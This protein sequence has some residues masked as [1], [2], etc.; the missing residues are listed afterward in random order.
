MKSINPQSIREILLE[1]ALAVVEEQW[2]MD[3]PDYR[4]ND[5]LRQAEQVRLE[6]GYPALEDFL[7]DLGARR[8]TARLSEQLLEAL[9]VGESYFFRQREQLE[10]VAGRLLPVMLMTSE[11]PV[12]MWSAGCSRGEEPFSLAIL[13]NY[14]G[15]GPESLQIL[16]TDLSESS[17]CRAREGRFRSFSMRG[18][19]PE[20][21]GMHF[22]QEGDEYE[23]H[24][25]IRA[26][27]RFARHNLADEVNPFGHHP[28][29]V[30]VCRNVLIYMSRERVEKVLRFLISCLAPGGYLVLGSSE[31]ILGMGL[32]IESLPLD[33]HGLYRR[34][35]ASPSPPPPRRPRPP[36]P[37]PPAAT[38]SETVMPPSPAPAP[39]PPT[40][41]AAGPDNA[42]VLQ[43]TLNHA[44]RLFESG[45][46]REAMEL[47]G[48]YAGTF[49]ADLAAAGILLHEGAVSDLKACLDR[50]LSN[51]PRHVAGYYFSALLALKN[52]APEKALSWLRRALYLDPDFVVGHIQ[53]ALILSQL[54]RHRE[55]EIAL[56]NAAR[57]L[58]ARRPEEPVP[59]ADGKSA[60]ELYRLIGKE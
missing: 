49:E 38:I 50:I 27:V 58:R 11:P 45:A 20:I 54:Q 57:L 1:S 17:L 28:V 21:L 53:S 25:S 9:I 44:A 12:R 3:F 13:S 26:R 15:V 55:S 29:D 56:Q 19:A 14:F 2:G 23:L 41:V 31:N 30:I 37:E 59:F 40:A 8:L 10:A 4:L 46:S 52:H 48:P 35:D 34:A 51:N 18:V 6:A 60:E 33:V 43:S 16:G 24:G 39:A 32:P 22:R 47:L 5:F 36:A 42:H 7:A